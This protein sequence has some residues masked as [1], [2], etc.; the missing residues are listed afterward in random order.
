MAKPPEDLLELLTSYDRG[1]Q[2]LAI[3]L[4]EIVLDELAPCC[5]YILEVYIISLMYGPTH[6]MK[7]GICYIGVIQDHVNLGFFHGKEMS[8]PDRILEGTG[9]AMRH[10]K[11]RD[12]TDLD[13]P[14][15]RVYLRE[16][17]E[18]MGHVPGSGRRRPVD[19]VV[20]R[21]NAKKRTLGR[22]SF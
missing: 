15:I 1:V 9:K 22:S 5:E 10:I 11:I 7:D 3:A 4:R 12:M 14:A 13:R 21:K 6:R 18:R 16:A 19:T 2:E 17:A 8:D 20:K